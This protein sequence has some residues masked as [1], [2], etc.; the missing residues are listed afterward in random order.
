VGCVQARRRCEA[1]T[2]EVEA[3]GLR[4]SRKVKLPF[5]LLPLH[6]ITWHRDRSVRNVSG[7]MRDNNGPKPLTSH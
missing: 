3:F 1:E 6:Y 7:N 2:F 5:P 4:E